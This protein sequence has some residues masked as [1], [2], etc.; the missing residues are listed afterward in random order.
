MYQVKENIPKFFQKKTVDA[1]IG[2]SKVPDARPK[3]EE[4]FFIS[5][6]VEAVIQDVG[7]RIKDDTIRTIFTN[8]LPSTLGKIRL[9]NF[10]HISQFIKSP[11]HLSIMNKI[12]CVLDLIPYNLVQIQ[13]YCFINDYR[14]ATSH[15]H[16]HTSSLEV[17]IQ[18]EF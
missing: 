12:Y 3:V 15:S 11:H 13:L 2:Q 6:T 7:S 4:R 14:M 9:I 8:C 10:D 18:T 16:I 17:T 1:E 5:E